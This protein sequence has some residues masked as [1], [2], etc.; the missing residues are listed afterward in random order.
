MARKLHAAA[1]REA[2]KKRKAGDADADD[3]KAGKKRKNY[4]FSGAA[5]DDG[6]GAAEEEEEKLETDLALPSLP[7]YFPNHT[8]E[9]D[10]LAL[11]D[12]TTLFT[13][14]APLLLAF[15]LVL[16][17]FTMPEQP[18][19]SRLSLA[20][21]VV[22]EGARKRAGDLG[23]VRTENAAEE[24]WGTGQKGVRVMGRSVSVMRRGV[25]AENGDGNGPEMRGSGDGDGEVQRDTDDL[26]EAAEPASALWALDLE[27]LKA[28][29]TLTVPSSS[30][31]SSS[32]ISNLPI[33]QP[34]GARA[35]LS[36]SF[37]TPPTSAPPP[38]I[39]PSPSSISSKATKAQT[40]THLKA[41]NLALLLHAL[42]LLFASWA[43][44]LSKEDL[45]RRAWGWYV[46]V[47]PDVEEGK[48]GWGGKGEVRLARVLELRRGK[49]DGGER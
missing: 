13:N 2:K 45:D 42:E 17:R 38:F 20:Q 7:A 18:L 23:I 12:A 25:G 33:H 44:V 8:A 48:A 21:A 4:G 11:L 47:R 35:Y 31:T 40:E 46:R 14:R 37:A 19:S 30:S 1:K 32:S 9:S 24:G 22:A 16:L 6:G 41:A 28:S 34:H 26:S 49:G 39:P 43:E 3:D 15:T 29:N 36:K 27:A 10:V 5:P